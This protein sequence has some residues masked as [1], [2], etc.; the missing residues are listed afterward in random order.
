MFLKLNEILLSHFSLF[1]IFILFEFNLK[2]RITIMIVNNIGH[3][4]NVLYILKLT[5]TKKKQIRVI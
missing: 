5:R 4:N 1:F 2:K 3:L